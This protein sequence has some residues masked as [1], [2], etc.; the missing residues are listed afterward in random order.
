MCGG[1][2]GG[3]GAIAASAGTCTVGGPGGAATFAEALVDISSCSSITFSLGA[4]G[5]AGTTAGGAGGTGGSTSITG[6]NS[7]GGLLFTIVAPGGFGGTGDTTAAANSINSS[8][9]SQTAAIVGAI[10]AGWSV[11][12]LGSRANATYVA[13]SFYYITGKNDGAISLLAQRYG[14]PMSADFQLFSSSNTL[15]TTTATGGA[16]QARYTVQFGC[17]GNPGW[18]IGSATARAGGA[19]TAGAII[20]TEYA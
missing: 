17:G 12:G 5:S 13:S 11:N 19:G 6:L 4:G 2:G 14:T 8:N 15:L 1:G 16:G 9:N 20:I 10:R 3:G 7:S 18:N